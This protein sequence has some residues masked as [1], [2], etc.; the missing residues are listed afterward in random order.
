M[1]RFSIV[2]EDE[3]PWVFSEE[4]II[5]AEK[6]TAE[7]GECYN[8]P[9]CGYKTYL[10]RGKRFQCQLCGREEEY[11]GETIEEW[12]KRIVCSLNNNMIPF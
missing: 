5:N 7:Y 12:H 1:G 8:C 4:E 3:S 11:C 9:E 10:D 2:C 6:E